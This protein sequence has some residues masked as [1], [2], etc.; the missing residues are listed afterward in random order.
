MQ[1]CPRCKEYK[2]LIICNLCNEIY[3]SYC[4]FDEE[5][6]CDTHGDIVETD[7]FYNEAYLDLKRRERF[8]LKEEE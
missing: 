4:D 3:C 1:Y 2:G 5:A 6:S 8:P 7:D